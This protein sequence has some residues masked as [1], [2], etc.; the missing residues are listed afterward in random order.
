MRNNK[1]IRFRFALLLLTAALLFAGCSRPDKGTATQSGFINDNT[2][3]EYLLCNPLAVKPLALDTEKAYCVAGD[4]SYYAIN[5]E[6]PTSFVADLDAESGSSFVYRSKELPD[7]TV[8][9]FHAI[10]ATLYIDGLTPRAVAQLYANDE[11]LPPELQGQNTSQDTALVMKMTD[12]LVNGA[13]RTVPVS[14]QDENEV[15]YFRL[16]SNLYPGLY[17][18][19]C[20]FADIYGKYYLEDLATRKTADA[21]DELVVWFVG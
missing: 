5:F 16:L 15:Y 6:E 19:I 10:A 7:I 1:K 11:Y 3:I 17:Y 18:N 12:A 21:P 4:V 20:F 13:A 8:E 9:S 14:E 2:G